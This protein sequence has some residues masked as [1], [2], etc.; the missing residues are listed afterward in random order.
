MFEMQAM[1]TA[2]PTALNRRLASHSVGV[3]TLGLT[4]LSLGFGALA[5]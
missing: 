1:L 2:G 5:A 4:V 3:C